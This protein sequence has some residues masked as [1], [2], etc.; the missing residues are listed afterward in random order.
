MQA[1]ERVLVTGGLGFIGAPLVHR[2][3]AEGYKVRVLD[4][5]S[6]GS[7]RR[8]ADIASQIEVVTG[9]IC[10]LD[11]V[12]RATDGCEIV[13]HLAAVNGTRNFYEKPHRVLE[14]G[15]KGAMNTIEAA[16][17]LGV[18]RYVAASSAEVYQQP[19]SVPTPETERLIVPN[20]HDPRYSY[21]GSKI[22]TE[23]LTL[24]YGVHLGLDAV[25]FRPH[26]IYGPDMGGEHVIPQFVLRMKRLSD[27]GKRNHFAFPIIGSG[28]ETRAFCYID[29][30]VDG[31][32]ICMRRGQKGNI[33]H[34]G[35]DREETSIKDLAL[36]TAKALDLEIDLIPGKQ[37]QQTPRRVPSIAKMQELGYEPRVSLVQGLSAT[38]QW[39]WRQDS[40]QFKEWSEFL[41]GSAHA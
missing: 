20:V 6:R 7:A 12:L 28:D 36:L 14:V 32:L 13:V 37:I 38:A 41:K 35:N 8:V 27:G 33:Y 15:V 24:H 16:L 23:L 3:A 17:K 10:S 40:A 4:N 9:D 19:T 21:G 18:K 26:N 2:L 31:I 30:A 25:I 34:I 22:A 5:G 29:D 1:S 39:Y 11:D